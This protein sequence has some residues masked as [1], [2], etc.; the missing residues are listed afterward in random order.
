MTTE[1]KRTIADLAARLEDIMPEISDLLDREKTAV[2]G[3]LAD[4]L[5]HI[6]FAVDALEQ[7][8]E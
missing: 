3:N 2:A 8:A 1:T 7:A 5:V 6:G 4:A